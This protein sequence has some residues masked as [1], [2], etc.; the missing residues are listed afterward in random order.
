MMEGVQ[1]MTL[2]WRIVLVGVWLATLC[3]LANGEDAEPDRLLR[4]YEIR[5]LTR[6]APEVSGPT[7]SLSAAAGARAERF[8]DVSPPMMGDDLDGAFIDRDELLRL[9]REV[10]PSV[11]WD[12]PGCM[13]RIVHGRLWARHTAPVLRRLETLLAS[14]EA[15]ALRTVRVRALFFTGGS[16]SI[17][18]G[19]ILEREDGARAWEEWR[20]GSGWREEVVAVGLE[21][22][23]MYACKG[24]QYLHVAEYDPQVASGA[25]VQDPVVAVAEV[26]AVLDVSAIRAPSGKRFTLVLR[27]SAA[28]PASEGLRRISTPAGALQAPAHLQ[29]TVE[30]TVT[31][32][33]GGYVVLGAGEGGFRVL[34]QASGLAEE[35]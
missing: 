3:T 34:L 7:L 27:L 25:Q 1:V 16:P 8:M 6:A 31:L 13:L 21:G 14:L 30:T 35:E 15:S 32:P 17:E 11:D 24:R 10:D 19:T 18:P 20:S 29:A 9:L 2:E 28:V 4:F 33:V 12:E 22:R 23:R 5:T 26:G